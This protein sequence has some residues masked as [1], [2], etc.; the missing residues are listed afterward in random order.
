MMR[1]GKFFCPFSRPSCLGRECGNYN[2]PDGRFGKRDKPLGCMGDNPTAEYARWYNQ[3][4]S[5]P[6]KW[7]EHKN[8]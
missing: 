3:R 6:T 2:D 7:C 5:V 1:D 4:F 8:K